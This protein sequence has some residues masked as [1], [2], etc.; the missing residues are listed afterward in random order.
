M[1]PI[2]PAFGAL[3]SEPGWPDF[4]HMTSWYLRFLTW[5]MEMITEANTHELI[6]V[7]PS[8]DCFRRRP[9]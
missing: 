6:N 1:G 3:D 5:E 8:E 4:S 7:Q 9:L 2:S